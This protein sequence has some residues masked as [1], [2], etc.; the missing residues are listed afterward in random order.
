MERRMSG[1]I[2]GT[3]ASLKSAPSGVALC[4]RAAISGRR[5]RTR[6]VWRPGMEK[7]AVC[8]GKRGNRQCPGVGGMVCSVCCG[9]KR[10]K[11][12]RCPDSCGILLALADDKPPAGGPGEAGKGG[13]GIG[14][15]GKGK[16]NALMRLDAWKAAEWDYSALM[17]PDML[18]GVVERP[19][20][21][22]RIKALRG[23]LAGCPEFYPA[24]V[25]LG[26]RLL[27]TGRE[28]GDEEEGRRIL[29][30]GVRGLLEFGEKNEITGTM[31]ACCGD[32]EK[33]F[34]Y[35]DSM[36]LYRAMLDAGIEPA[37]AH[38]GLG[39]CLSYVGTLEDAASEIQLVVE[40]EPGKAV[41]LSNLAH[42]HIQRG[43][44][45]ATEVLL[46][47]A[48][49]LD[50]KEPHTLG[51]MKCLEAMRRRGG[52][53]DWKAFLLDGPDM[54]EMERLEEDE[55]YIGVARLAG[56]H[57]G[58][59]LL[60]FR[61]ELAGRKDITPAGKYDLMFSIDRF[62]NL[63]ARILDEEPFLLSDMITV[64]AGFQHVLDRF[65]VETSDVDRQI[66]DEMFNSVREFY[67]FLAREEVVSEEAYA[68]LVREM[69]DTRHGIEDRMDRYSAVRRAPG[70]TAIKKARARDKI[71][72][73]W[74]DW[75]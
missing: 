33:R 64:H 37:E 65:V 57:N 51:N 7:C 75:P 14:K 12:I 17:A 71:Y 60:A 16:D 27:C 55:D 56:E 6:Q 20:A 49:R 35:E 10:L 21:S 19:A 42:T 32:L 67:G 36:T 63:A 1:C 3:S 58:N 11:T 41:F 29:R 8:G 15:R 28:K 43:D 30:E 22:D 69:K 39:Y 62:T 2:G 50:S 73:A 74:A 31:E 44:L 48:L 46:K 68:G 4:N 5:R 18:K 45:D 53:K 66:L 70:V 24:R 25:D 26:L 23:I 34:L 61:K 52:P 54:R 40:A 38:D 47:K 9:T 72:G 59:L 13:F